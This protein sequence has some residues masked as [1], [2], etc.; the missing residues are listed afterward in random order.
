MSESIEN[1]RTTAMILT[2]LVV[3]GLMILNALPATAREEF[4]RGFTSVS[5]PIPPALFVALAVGLPVMLHWVS[6]NDPVYSA[7]AV[8][9]HRTVI[10]KKSGE[11]MPEPCVNCG[12]RPY[13]GKERTYRT[14]YVVLGYAVLNVEKGTNYECNQCFE[15]DSLE[16]FKR[17]GI[18]DDILDVDDDELAEPA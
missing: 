5:G 15:A 16:Y 7:L 1:P 17:T 4:M 14:D 10:T 18:H 11:P 13:H 3:I 12:K 8:G 2:T 9:R 6:E